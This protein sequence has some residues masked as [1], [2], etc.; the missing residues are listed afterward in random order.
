MS[1]FTMRGASAVPSI[2]SL[3]CMTYS[4]ITKERELV[5]IVQ[6]NPK[7]HGNVILYAAV[8]ILLAMPGLVSDKGDVST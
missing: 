3:L 7:I 1:K 6:T 8:V 4:P 5:P 2:E